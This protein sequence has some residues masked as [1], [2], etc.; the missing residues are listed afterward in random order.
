MLFRLDDREAQLNLESAK[1]RAQNARD[2]KKE[3]EL[4]VD[5]A[6]DR[7]A[8][9]KIDFRQAERTL[10]RTKESASQDLASKTQLEDAQLSYDQAENAIALAENALAVAAH[11]LVK[12]ATEVESAKIQVRIQER[13][14][15]DYSVRAPIDG[16]IPELLVRGGEW[17][18]QTNPLCTI[19]AHD[20]LIL[21]LR[22]PQ[23]ELGRLRAGQ[24]VEIE[25]DAWPGEKFAGSIDFVSPIVDAETG[26]FI[27]R[28]R[29]ERDENSRLR[30]GMFCRAWIVTGTSHAALMIPKQAIV[31]EAETPFAFVVREGKA[32]RISIDRGIDLKD[33]V[34]ARNVAPTAKPG[35]FTRG[36]RIVVVGV[37]GLA[38]GGVEVQVVKS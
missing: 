3:A 20:Q 38:T 36:D 4:Q 30:P 6:K 23:K 14:L 32:E 21:N 15:E 16:V 19:V 24:S 7:V 29:L 37:D 18:A 5:E 33:A 26:T 22:R 34:E 12:A 8:K 27:A 11:G 9:A 28:V 31:Y 1:N 10:E 13:L 17:V 2:M 35:S 25:V